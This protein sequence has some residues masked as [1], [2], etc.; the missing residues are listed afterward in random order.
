MEEEEEEEEDEDDENHS[1]VNFLEAAFVKKRFRI[2]GLKY[3]FLVA[4]LL[5]DFPVPKLPFA[6]INERKAC[7]SLQ[8]DRPCL[9]RMSPT[10]PPYS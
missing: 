2:I 1:N 9:Q 7:L 6:R 5:T 10:C 8:G 3:L 4:V